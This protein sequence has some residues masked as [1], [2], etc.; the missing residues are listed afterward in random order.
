MKKKIRNKTKKSIGAS[1]RIDRQS[2]IYRKA[3]DLFLAKGYDATS[4]TMIAKRLGMSKANL[5]YYCPSKE[6]LLYQIHLGDLQ[7]RFVPI[8]EEA[9]KISDPK[10]RLTLFFR[11]FALMCASSPASRVLI[12]EV[13]SLERS[14]YNEI[15]A[16]WKRGYRLIYKSIKELQESGRAHKFRLPFL[17]FLGA[18]MVFWIVYWFDYS[19]QNSSEELAETLVQ[20]FLNGLLYSPS[21]KRRLLLSG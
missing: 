20:V 6:G 16:I 11:K 10:E 14:H 4:L 5:Y 12:H 2:E 19:R 17:T 15:T 1:R 7:T 8:I 3:L 13:R 18:G 9:K 21:R